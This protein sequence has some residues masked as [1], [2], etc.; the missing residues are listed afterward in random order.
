MVLLDKARAYEQNVTDL[1]MAT[2]CLGSNVDALVFATKVKLLVRDPVI[3]EAVVLNAFLVCIGPVIKQYASPDQTAM[4]APMVDGV[5]KVRVRSNDIGFVCVVVKCSS[6][7]VS[8]LC[9]A[10]AWNRLERG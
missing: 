1:D 6:S 7:Q 4:L 10:S 3:D 5:F 9:L 8:E 2:L